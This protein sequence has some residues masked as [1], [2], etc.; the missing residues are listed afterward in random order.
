MSHNSMWEL[1]LPGCFCSPCV[2]ASLR[3]LHSAD[4]TQSAH[5]GR[6]WCEAK[7]LSAVELDSKKVDSW[8]LLTSLLADG[9][10][11]LSWRWIWAAYLLAYHNPPLALHRSIS[12][13]TF[14]EQVLQDLFLGELKRQRLAGQTTVPNAAV[15]LGSTISICHLPLH[16]QV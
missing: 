13:H 4:L 15:R 6:A 12:P 1:C 14:R 5:V 7:W 8:R 2:L 10:Q 3:Q 9:Q 16:Y 11:I